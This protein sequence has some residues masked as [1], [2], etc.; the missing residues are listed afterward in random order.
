MEIKLVNESELPGNAKAHQIYALH[1]APLRDRQSQ[2]GMM[3]VPIILPPS[4]KSEYIKAPPVSATAISPSAEPVEDVEMTDSQPAL[5]A[6][7][8]KAT[9]AVPEPTT[10]AHQSAPGKRM[11]MVKVTRTFTENG[12]QMTETVNEMVP[13][14]EDDSEALPAESNSTTAASSV[15]PK[16]A[17]PTAAKQSNLMSFFKKAKQ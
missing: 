12:Y 9:T 2:L 15:K 1:K 7:S 11:K 14:E 3:N 8:V 6:E 10:T 13:C 5:K 4:L 17:A 16:A